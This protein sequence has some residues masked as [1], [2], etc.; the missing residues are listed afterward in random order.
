MTTGSPS[1]STMMTTGQGR[2]ATGITPMQGAGVSLSMVGTGLSVYGGL[3]AGKANFNSYMQQSDGARFQGMIGDFNAAQ[4]DLDAKIAIQNSELQAAGIVRSATDQ[5]KNLRESGRRLE[6]Q[7]RVSYAKSGVRMSG[8]PLEVMAQSAANVEMDAVNTKQEALWQAD[9]TTKQGQFQAA[10]LRA[11]SQFE[12]LQANQYRQS[13][14]NYQSA[15]SQAWKNS[16]T[17]AYASIIGGAA[18][19]AMMFI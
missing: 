19:S 15:A 12:R 8:T 10:Q 13:A 14:R 2:A 7:Q 16:K 5:A 18:N 1:R 17:N 4:L 3:Q 9:N 6:G 11:Q